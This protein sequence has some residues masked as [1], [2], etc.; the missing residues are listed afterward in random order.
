[1]SYMSYTHGGNF[2]TF[3]YN[4]VHEAESL[5]EILPLGIFS[6]L[7]QFQSCGFQKGV[8]TLNNVNRLTLAGETTSGWTERGA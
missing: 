8:L 7:Q 5:S 4:C 1:M 3:R 6:G 2:I